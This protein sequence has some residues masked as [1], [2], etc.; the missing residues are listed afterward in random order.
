MVRFQ[1][2]DRPSAVTGKEAFKRAEG[3]LWAGP[4]RG[5]GRLA[6]QGFS[7]LQ[8]P[9]FCSSP[10]ISAQ[11]FPTCLRMDTPQLL[12]PILPQSKPSEESEKPLKV[13]IPNWERD[14]HESALSQE[15]T[16]GPLSHS[17][18]VL[19]TWLPEP[20]LT[21][22]AGQLPQTGAEGTVVESTLSK[23][24]SVGSKEGSRKI[25]AE[26]LFR[27]RCFG[28]C[29]KN[30]EFHSLEKRVRVLCPPHARNS[31]IGQKVGDLLTLKELT[32]PWECHKGN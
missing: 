18:G 15:S 14:C 29:L 27:A 8:L 13:K 30:K 7:S 20:T 21:E 12:E 11:A 2:A 19:Q 17:L 28:K 6:S 4:S 31:A 22:G 3:L 25:E 10:S 16:P 24:S 23:V 1:A 32:I 9:C 26:F 5:P